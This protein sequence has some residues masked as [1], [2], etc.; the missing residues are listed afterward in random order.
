MNLPINTEDIR[1]IVVEVTGIILGTAFLALVGSLTTRFGFGIGYRNALRHLRQG[2]ALQATKQFSEALKEI[3]QSINLLQEHPRER[4]LAEAYLRLGDIELEMQKWDSAVEH[5]RLY[6]QIAPRRARVPRD[7]ICVRLGSAYLGAGKLDEAFRNFDEARRLQ[8]HTDQNPLL[9][10]TYIRLAQT[11]IVRRHPEVAREH[12]LRAITVQEQL[13]DR[14]GE[15]ASRVSLAAIYCDTQE[16]ELARD[17]YMIAG[18]LYSEVGDSG[19][20]KMIAEKTN[21]LKICN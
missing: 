2:Q 21:S 8:E 13:R 5:F 15:A 17:Q 16:A 19:I 1:R 12:Y 11:E 6:G 10:E 3:E 9:G 14:R 20:A 7:L 18:R 4:T